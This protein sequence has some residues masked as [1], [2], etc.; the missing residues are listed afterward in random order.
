MHGSARRNRRA[1]QSCALVPRLNR[2][3][4]EL[5]GGEH[6]VAPGQA[7]VFYD[8]EGPGAR[9]LGG[10]WITTTGRPAMMAPATLDHDGAEPTPAKQP[11]E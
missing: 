11:A 4:V 7:C 10:G 5:T 8:R 3:V 2:R 6:G 1:R 9:V